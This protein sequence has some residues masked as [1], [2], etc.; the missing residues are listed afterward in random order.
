[1]N[2]MI[3]KARAGR[4]KALEERS[5]RKSITTSLLTDYARDASAAR[6]EMPIFI[7]AR[8]RPES[9]CYLH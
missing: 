6:N 5:V 4:V 8:A 7:S 2:N 9:I 3:E 1:M